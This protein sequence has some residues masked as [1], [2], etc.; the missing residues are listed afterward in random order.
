MF[1]LI[2]LRS[3]AAYRKGH[4]VDARWSIRPR[5]SDALA[6]ARPADPVVLFS[7]APELA[8]L[9]ALDL[10]EAGFTSVWIA[11]HGIATWTEAGL[12]LEASPTV[13]ADNERIDHL[14]FV[15]DR[16]EG[17]LDAARAY[18]AW[19]TGLIAQCAAD[20]L[21]HFRINANINTRSETSASD[22]AFSH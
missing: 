2:D 11:K 21:N 12:V 1:N 9:A 3:S 7:E 14:F 16:H 19:E 6:S 13:P 18:L 20:E 10:R 5:L 4:P 15:H 8:A 22:A 17:N